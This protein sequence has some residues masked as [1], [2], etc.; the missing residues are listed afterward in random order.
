MGSGRTC[1][2]CRYAP[3]LV[4]CKSIRVV[5]G[6]SGHP[7]DSRL[8]SKLHYVDPALIVNAW[9]CGRRLWLRSLLKYRVNLWPP[10]QVS[11]DYVAIITPKSQAKAIK[12]TT[13]KAMRDLL[14]IKSR[15]KQCKGFLKYVVLYDSSTKQYAQQFLLYKDKV[16]FHCFSKNRKLGDDGSYFN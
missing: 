9:G 1:A 8:L 7:M 10:R 6:A 15:H 12:I 5:S 16:T 3:P 11:R 2:P 4:Y 14:Y 13:T